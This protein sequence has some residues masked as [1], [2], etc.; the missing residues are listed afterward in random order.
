MPRAVL[1]GLLSLLMVAGALGGLLSGTARAD[2]APLD[3]TDPL[4][5]A[6]VT[7]DGLPTVQI[8]GVAWAQAV[9][10][11]TVYVGGRFSSARPAG[12]PAGSQETTRNNLLAYDIRTGNL[13]TSFA[14]DLNGQVLAVTAS[15]DGKRLYV[16]GD[17]TTANGQDRY[18]VAAY[19]TATGALVPDFRPIAGYQVAAIAATDSTV[20]LGGGFS[21]MNGSPRTRL[22]AVRASDGSLL[23]WAPVAGAGVNKDGRTAA[24]YSVTGIVLPR[25]GG[26]VVVSG[27]FGSLNGVRTTGIGSVDAI[28]GDTL[29][30]AVGG[31]VTNQGDNAAVYSLSTDG[32]NVYGTGYDYNGPG[33]VEGTFAADAATGELVWMA[34]CHGDSYSSVPLGGVVYV[35]GHPH[36]C[37][38]IGGF[39]EANPRLSQYSLALSAAPSGTTVGNAT[40]NNDP[41][42]RG[43]PAPRILDWW[44]TF[45]S[46]T[47]TGQGQAG[48]SVA[49]N[50]QYVVFAGE[51][52]GVNNKAQAG[53]VRFAVPSLAP[54]AIGPD[55]SAGLTPT[56]SSFAAD[57]AR[58]SW[59]T[60]TDR[61]NANLTYSVHR[62]D[63]PGTPVYQT[64]AASVYR[65]PAQRLG[66][67]DT[68]VTAGQTYD[69]RV[70]A[71]DPF[72]NTVS[73]G[74]TSVT[75]ATTGS[76][77]GAYAR[78]VRNDGATNYWRLGERSGSTAYDQGLAGLD[79]S[80]GS[81]VT[82]GRSGA[83]TGDTD[84]A[85]QFSGN[86]TG[87]ASTQTAVPGPDTFTIE[88]FVRTTTTSGGKLV[89]FGSSRTMATSSNYDRHLYLD[90]S[91]HLY[92]GVYP[93][94][95]RTLRSTSRVNDGQWHQVVATLSS[96][97]MALYVDGELVGSRAD[98]TSA[99]AYSGY[100]RLGGDSTW[101]G[102]G[103]WFNG[104]L[105]EVAI[106]PT[107]LTAEQ[108][109]AHHTAATTGKAPNLAP[110][111]A[112]TSSA[113]QLA[114]SLDGSS[115]S[116]LDGR[117]VSWAWEF[118]DGA[119]GS[120]AT[121]S[122]T[123]AAAGSY[124]V[125]LTVT[126]DQGA[127]SST[128]RTLT[129]T[130][131]PPNVEPTAAFTVTTAQ[132]T[133]S[134]DGSSSSDLDG[135]VVSWA[136][137]FGDGAT[138]SGATASHTYAAAGSYPVTLTV[139]DDE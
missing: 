26:N 125:T 78:T 103:T 87:L 128:T 35:A 136:W 104:Q 117:V 71:S 134:L 69:Y 13:I 32:T 131:P 105:D 50:S 55:S 19:D 48:W 61:D 76:L 17:F 15:P 65:L 34:D 27:R 16:G 58:V 46:G 85:Y 18:R 81:G 97:G 44:P 130:A 7:A 79:L 107:A 122:H 82:R 63:R 24:N 70:T 118:G 92:F 90:R 126:D 14:P 86:F 137:E 73:S 43:K 113:D 39:P 2:S 68:E 74:T 9:V 121:A 100:W 25:D 59:S 106:Y 3:P 88:T 49:G 129:V 108:V 80:T 116:D 112:F 133:A 75:V 124:P 139:T 23:P 5:P 12:A 77:G 66:F 42:F 84:T 135:R 115:S 64:T 62:S 60:T 29:P 37:S 127:T 114:V 99:Q 53:L 56:V 72:G 110:T 6:T 95:E 111:A 119:T 109:A 89:G 93:G 132:L 102:N 138:G 96:Q 40:F 8:D 22:A 10:G 51:F 123:Y 101:G 4:S 98:T 57:S 31:M 94:A 91:G 38:N 41:A 1:A 47:V 33:N 28:T 54:N 67:L 83:L 30:F 11:T 21:S 20:Y 52:P 120:G 45:L 36:V